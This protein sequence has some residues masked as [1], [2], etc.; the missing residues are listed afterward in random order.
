[1]E[2]DLRYTRPREATDEI[3]GIAAA[4]LYASDKEVR[5]QMAAIKRKNPCKHALVRDQLRQMREA[6]GETVEDSN[7]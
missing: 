5:K 3:K 7:E 6:R 2:R 1:M 4:M